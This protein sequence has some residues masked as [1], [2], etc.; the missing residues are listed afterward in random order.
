MKN[1][2]FVSSL[3]V[4]SLFYGIAVFATE[5]ALLGP[6]FP[7]PGGDSLA[8]TYFNPEQS[9][10]GTGGVTWSYSAFNL[11]AFSSLYWGPTSNNAVSCALS[12]GSGGP[13]TFSG[14]SGN[15]AS[16]TGTATYLNSSL[17]YSTVSTLFQATVNSAATPWVLASTLGLDPGIGAVINDSSGLAYSVNLQF[18]AAG[19]SLDQFFN[20]YDHGS[21]DSASISGGFYYAA[22]IPEPSAVAFL[23]LA[24]PA[25]RMLRRTRPSRRSP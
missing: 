1:C 9:A 3:L 23:L 11:S 15:T 22:P 25:L 17:T 6:I 14:I 13:M 12:G 16:W 24:A 2:R 18:T 7:A 21:A 19:M 4:A 10:G 20:T 8:T 5:A